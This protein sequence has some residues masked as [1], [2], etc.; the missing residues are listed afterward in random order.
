MTSRE[1]IREQL[2]QVKRERGDDDIL[3]QSLKRELDTMNRRQPELKPDP[4]RDARVAALSRA[5]E[6]KADELE[7]KRGFGKT[8]TPND[9]QNQTTHTGRA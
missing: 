1:L 6:E 3:T 8:S 7:A 2:E 9:H 5:M 4:A